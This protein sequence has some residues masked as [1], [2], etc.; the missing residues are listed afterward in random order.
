MKKP[1]LIII[2][3]DGG[4]FKIIDPLIEMGKLPNLKRLIEN[5]TKAILKSTIPPLTAPAWVSL[6]TGVNAGKHGLFEFRKLDKITYDTP[7]NPKPKETC[8]LMHSR[9]Y[10]G[11]TIWDILSRNGL[12]VSILMMPMTYPAWEVNGYMLSGFP[13]PDFKNP[14]GYPLEWASTIGPLFDMSAVAVD[15]EDRLI[16]ECH[17]L[18]NKLET[19]FIKQLKNSKCDVHCVVFSSTDFLQHFLWKYL[20]NENSKYSN[21]IYDMYVEID[22]YIGNIL[23]LVDNDNCTFVVLS[24]HGFTASPENYFHTNAWLISEGYLVYSEKNLLNKT[25][26][27]LLNPLRYQKVKLRLFLKSYFKYLPLAFQKKISDSYYGTN[28]FD[29]IK[30]KAFRYRIGMA[31]GIVI[32]LKGRQPSGIVDEAEYEILRNEIIEKLRK[33]CDKEQ[34][35]KVVSEIYKR[36]EIYKGKFVEL[37]P[38]IIF[39]LNSKYKGSVGINTNN[40]IENIPDEAI[41]AI[42]GGHDMDGMLILS[43]PKINKNIEIQPVGIID[44]FPTILCDLGIPI[45]SYVDGKVI[46][47]AFKDE[48]VPLPVNYIENEMWKEES[49][50]NLSENEE[51]EMKKALKSLGYLN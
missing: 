23:E 24:D 43:G 11:K 31:E 26:D 19:V 13:S 12:K 17:Q 41:G 40:V 7:F 30:S 51:E 47:N 3:L 8:N 50:L 21:A 2:G 37:V 42:S 1:K 49:D 46:K 14:T 48:F 28:I 16:D 35:M 6:M 5:G 38:D 20:S 36:E 27:F 22:K 9:Y 34:G 33:I 45:P 18:V 4:T 29:W 25:I 39:M 15:N 10:A 32:N 44:I